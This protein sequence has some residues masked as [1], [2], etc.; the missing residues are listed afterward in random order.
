MLGNAVLFCCWYSRLSS[1]I[2]TS[3]NWQS[4]AL[5]CI[6]TPCFAVQSILSSAIMC[7]AVLYGLQFCAVLYGLQFCAVLYGLQ[8]CTVLYGF[9]CCAVLC[10]FQCC[11]VQFPVL[12]CVICNCVKCSAYISRKNVL[13][14]AMRCYGCSSIIV[15]LHS[16]VFVLLYRGMCR[17]LVCYVRFHLLNLFLQWNRRWT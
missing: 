10:G 11:A 2:C 4:C 12:C 6:D 17:I 3:Y 9:Q 7:S 1:A 5:L 13:S 16:I 15:L 8:C 14:I